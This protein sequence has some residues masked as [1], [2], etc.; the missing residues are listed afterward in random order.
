MET[1]NIVAALFIVLI[2][3]GL[4]EL[5]TLVGMAIIIVGAAL[6]PKVG[7]A[8]HEIFSGPTY[9]YGFD[10]KQ[11]P[12]LSVPIAIYSVLVAPSALASAYGLY[13]RRAWAL[14]LTG[15]LVITQIVIFIGDIRSLDK[16][17]SKYSVV[18]KE[19]TGRTM[20]VG[21]VII[22]YGFVAI[23]LGAILVLWLMLRT[24]KDYAPVKEARKKK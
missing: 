15:I 6:I 22:R 20:D 2:I 8:V 7:T 12:L 5:E 16:N 9:L 21:S 23:L 13:K 17:Y 10:I 18:L 24:R 19:Q 1:K 4:L 11:I 14:K 3:F